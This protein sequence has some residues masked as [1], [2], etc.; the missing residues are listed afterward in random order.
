M[1]G[2]ISEMIYWN[3]LPLFLW[4]EE[5]FRRYKSRMG[6]RPNFLSESWKCPE[7]RSRLMSGG[8]WNWNAFWIGNFAKANLEDGGCFGGWGNEDSGNGAFKALLVKIDLRRMWWKSECWQY[9]WSTGWLTDW[10]STR[11]YGGSWE[12]NSKTGNEELLRNHPPLNKEQIGTGAVWNFYCAPAL[13][14]PWKSAGGA[15]AI[16]RLGNNHHTTI[17]SLAHHFRICKFSLLHSSRQKAGEAWLQ[18]PAQV[19]CQ[20]FSPTRYTF[21]WI[22]SVQR[23]FGSHSPTSLH[24]STA[25]SLNLHLLPENS[26]FQSELIESFSSLE[27]PEEGRPH[28]YQNLLLFSLSFISPGDPPPVLQC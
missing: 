28:S 12:E 5:G 8:V 21:S 7:N 2:R 1:R 14:H 27:A 10:L 18:D 25:L 3:L 4:R 9:S 16:D 13:G 22:A 23:S 26:S 19:S 6:R 11:E 15:P 24:H 20:L 17:N